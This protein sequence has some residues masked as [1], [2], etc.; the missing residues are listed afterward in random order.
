MRGQLIFLNSSSKGL[1]VLVLRGVWVVLPTWFFRGRCCASH[2][3]LLYWEERGLFQFL[4]IPFCVSSTM[5]IWRFFWYFRLQYD[6]DSGAWQ[7]VTDN[8]RSGS[9]V[10][11]HLGKMGVTSSILVFGSGKHFK[12][13][14]EI[15]PGY[16]SGQ[17]GQSVKLLAYAYVG[18]SPSPGTK[19]C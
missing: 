14:N 2:A 4:Q 9:V 11:H 1:V 16:S 8:R 15:M 17:R 13:N 3:R 18:S 6:S 12:R 5:R 19:I 10:E 7:Y